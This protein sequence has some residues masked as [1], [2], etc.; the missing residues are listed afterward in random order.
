MTVYFSTA[1]YALQKPFNYKDVFFSFN[2]GT[3]CSQL[4]LKLGYSTQESVDSS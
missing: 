3:L 4:S 1:F 2:A